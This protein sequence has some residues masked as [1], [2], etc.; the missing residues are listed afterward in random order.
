M[1][2][3]LLAPWGCK[4]RS[5]TPAPAEKSSALHNAPP[6]YVEER[7]RNPLIHPRPTSGL[8]R[9]AATRRVVHIADI[10]TDQA[11]LD[12]VPSTVIL[13][14]TAGARTVVVV[15]MLKEEELVVAIAIY[16]QEVRPFTDKQIRSEE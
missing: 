2:K 11:Y 8:G 12:G 1:W 14:D 7:R 9:L 10:R 6:A 5:L 16:R 4:S 13:A 3:R 15:P